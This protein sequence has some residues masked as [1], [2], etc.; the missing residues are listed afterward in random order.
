MRIEDI[1]A[2]R[3]NR[4]QWH[5]LAA[6]SA[7]VAISL[8]SIMGLILNEH[9]KNQQ[10]VERLEQR[11]QEEIAGAILGCQRANQRTLVMNEIL[12]EIGRTDL[13]APRELDCRQFIIDTRELDPGPTL[14]YPPGSSFNG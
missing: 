9:R 12:E 6:F 4:R 14:R 8:G 5:Y 13:E 3:S 2:R 10:T 7:I 11:E 1:A